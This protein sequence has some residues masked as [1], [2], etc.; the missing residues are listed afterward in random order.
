MLTATLACSIPRWNIGSW[1]FGAGIGRGFDV[2]ALISASL[3]PFNLVFRPSPN[4][5]E[6]SK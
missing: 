5:A 2:I 1:D 4:V 3:P 6:F